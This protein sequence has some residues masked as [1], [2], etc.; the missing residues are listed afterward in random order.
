MRGE[1]K[2]TINSFVTD[3]QE[4]ARDDEFLAEDLAVHDSL[5]SAEEIA[6]VERKLGCK[7]PSVLVDLMKTI[8]ISGV[9]LE[10]FQFGMRPFS[11]PDALV[12]SN[13]KID[14]PEIFTD[15]GL[16]T[17]GLEM[18]LAS[19]ICI[20]RERCEAEDGPPLIILDYYSLEL[21]GP[22]Y[23]D[24]VTSLQGQ[25]YLFKSRGEDPQMRRQ[26]LREII[27]LTMEGSGK[28]YWDEYF[29]TV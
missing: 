6:N 25:V 11:F 26:G 12:E 21:I 1:K 23:P 28:K 15:R 16:L 22:I 7:L 19:P 18:D 4:L 5:P 9:Q 8:D 10:Q 29:T 13:I 20:P 2:Y 14:K 24:I 27:G 17:I 3:I